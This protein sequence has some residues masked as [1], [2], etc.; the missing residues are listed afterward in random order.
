M[1]KIKLI[2]FDGC[3]NVE[4][5]KQ[6]L[7]EAGISFEE[8]KQD[9]LSNEDHFKSYSSP[10]ILDGDIIIFGAKT[11][12]GGGGCSLEIPTVE[13]LM[14]KLG[15]QGNFSVARKA[16]SGLLSAIGSLGSAITVG[17]C[18]IC[19]PAFGAFLSAIGLGFLVNE[20]I[21]YPVLL[22]FLSTTIGGLFWSY[23]K[24]H[25]NI[26]PL[27]LGILSGT[28]IYI[29]RYIYL[30]ALINQVLMYGGIVGIIGVSLLNLKLRKQRACPSCVSERNKS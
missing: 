3:P 19:I 11:A 25:G 16:H 24:E 23:R 9:E 6:T 22:I 5:T 30:G 10:T 1:K 8:I 21:L 28:A 12:A 29:G 13:E 26:F 27:I 7:K 2:Y 15:V 4:K 20:S 17:L 14:A 18:P